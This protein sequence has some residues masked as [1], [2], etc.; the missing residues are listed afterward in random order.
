MNKFAKKQQPQKFVKKQ[1]PV[2][3]AAKDI[4]VVIPPS[5]TEFTLSRLGED[6][7]SDSMLA[8]EGGSDRTSTPA[9]LHKVLKMRKEYKDAIYTVEL[10]VWNHHLRCW[11]LVHNKDKGVCRVIAQLASP[12][13][14]GTHEDRKDAL[15]RVAEAISVTLPILLDKAN[16][17]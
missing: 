5:G 15:R 6:Y 1:P 9:K 4:K 8:K 13:A 14:A 11:V 12:V 7:Q 10:H 16:L 2:E 17:P 3:A